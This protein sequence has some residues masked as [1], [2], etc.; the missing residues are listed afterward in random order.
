MRGSSARKPRGFA[1]IIQYSSREPRAGMYSVLPV[2][3]MRLHHRGNWKIA[4][5]GLG[6]ITLH[7]GYV[8]CCICT[9]VM[10]C[11]CAGKGK[12]TDDFGRVTVASPDICAWTASV[13]LLCAGFIYL[14]SGVAE[15]L[16]GFGCNTDGTVCGQNQFSLFGEGR[17]HISWNLKISGKSSRWKIKQS[18]K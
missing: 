8:L 2:H 3:C 7:Y 16:R 4:R 1:L 18:W 13:Q 6:A 11:G 17:S 15:G 5:G 12:R 10:R 14:T 9:A